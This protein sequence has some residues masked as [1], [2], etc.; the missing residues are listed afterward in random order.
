MALPIV[1]LKTATVD[2]GD[3]AT[4]EVRGMTRAEC[5]AMNEVIQSGKPEDADYY[6]VS[7]GTNTELSEATSWVDSAPL[8]AV[9]AI[10]T[11]VLT[12]SGLGDDS[13]KE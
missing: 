11:A 12:L 9:I 10:S 8:D 13:P 7:Y 1:K 4:V 2:L 6:V 3:G 5:L